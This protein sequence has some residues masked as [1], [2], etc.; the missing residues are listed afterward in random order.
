MVGRVLN[1]AIPCKK[2][3]RKVTHVTLFPLVNLTGVD[4]P[5]LT[6]CYSVPVM[7]GVL[8]WLKL[9]LDVLFSP[10]RIRDS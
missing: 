9:Y 2:G 4:C 1:Y 6:H 7:L 5:Y 3:A 10:A 8:Q